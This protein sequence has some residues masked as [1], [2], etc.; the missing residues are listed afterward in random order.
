MTTALEFLNGVSTA[1][2]LTCSWVL[3][4]TDEELER[5]HDW[6]QWAFPLSV[7]S[8]FN[9]DAPLVTAEFMQ[10]LPLPARTAFFDMV[11]RYARF[12]SSTRHWRRPGDHNHLRITRLLTSMWLAGADAHAWG[13]Y[14]F[15]CAQ[16]SP[17]IET[18]R[19]WDEAM[20]VL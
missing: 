8:R 20:G 18:R 11:T 14:N 7:P 19:Y 3:N 9:P 16:G 2:G 15:V 17:T 5:R 12:L 6:V 1:G 10:A 13:I 4:A